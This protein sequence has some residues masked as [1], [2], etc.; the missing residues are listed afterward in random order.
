MRVLLGHG[1][2]PLARDRTGEDALMKAL[3]FGEAD[4][5]IA[6]LEA[7][8]DFRS[9]LAPGTGTTFLQWVAGPG[10]QGDWCPPG[11]PYHT[12]MARIRDWLLAHRVAK[13]E[14]GPPRD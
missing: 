7:G 8:A 5:V 11:G 2:D 10:P 4:C 6:M 9:A 1:A 12:A 14:L 3:M 13:E